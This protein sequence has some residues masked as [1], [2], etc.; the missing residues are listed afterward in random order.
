MTKCN[1]IASVVLTGYFVMTKVR[2]LSQRHNVIT[3]R[4]KFFG[5][6][7]WVPCRAHKHWVITVIAV[8]SVI[9]VI[10]Y[11]GGG[12]STLIATHPSTGSQN[13]ILGSRLS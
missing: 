13:V 2:P 12:L 7:V 1:S 5:L 9:T 3:E 11:I 8:M 6:E 4:G 10:T